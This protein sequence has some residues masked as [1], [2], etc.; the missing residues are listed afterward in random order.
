MVD[1]NIPQNK[2][3]LIFQ[4]GRNFFGWIASSTVAVIIYISRLI[5]SGSLQECIDD[6]NEAKLMQNFLSPDVSLI[7]KSEFM[8]RNSGL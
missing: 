7:R 3:R 6:S 4:T 8:A 5:F 2:L 1:R